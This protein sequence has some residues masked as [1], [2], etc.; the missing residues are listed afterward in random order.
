MKIK[1]VLPIWLLM[2]SG[3]VPALTQSPSNHAIN[4]AWQTTD[5]K[6]EILTL[7]SGSL[8]S[9]KDLFLLAL[10]HTHPRNNQPDY[11]AARTYL[12]RYLTALSERQSSQWS[13]WRAQHMHHLVGTIQKLEEKIGRNESQTEVLIWEQSDCQKKHAECT[14][15]LKG[16]RWALKKSKKSI[17]M[18]KQ[19]LKEAQT[20]SEDTVNEIDRLESENTKLKIQLKKLTDLYINLEK[21]RRAIQ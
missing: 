21:K 3:C 19:Q 18:T 1:T 6:Q 9:A 15:K 7:E 11:R 4:Q 14:K 16:L 12:N 17:S 8:S 10:L 5:I 2:I 13:D 20:L